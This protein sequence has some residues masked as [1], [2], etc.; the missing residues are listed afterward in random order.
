[1]PWVCFVLPIYCWTWGWALELFASQWNSAGELVF[2]C[3]HLSIRYSFWVSA[4][5]YFCS[6]CWESI[7]FI[8]CTLPQ[9]VSSYMCWSCCGMSSI[10]SASYIVLPP[11]PQGP[12]SPVGTDE[13]I[14]FNTECSQVSHS[15][16]IA[17]LWVS[18]FALIY[19]RRKCLWWWLGKNWSGHNRMLRGMILW[20]HSFS[21]KEIFGYP[22]GPSDI[23]S[24]ALGHQ[25]WVPS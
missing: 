24:L 18:L 1:M 17:Q 2:L 12:M 10:P 6:Q 16:H 3:E 11:L 23:W 13:N 15:L 20:L 7:W 5:V 25:S 4:C 8:L 19:C 9:S 14:P 21:R 22:L